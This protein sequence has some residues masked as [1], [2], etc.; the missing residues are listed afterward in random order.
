MKRILLPAV[1]AMMSL[2]AFAQTPQQINYQTIVRDAT[3]APLANTPVKLLFVI[4]DSTAAGPTVYQEVTPQLSTNGFGLVST[5]IGANANLAVVP[6]AYGTKW[7]EV[8]TEING[9]PA[10]TSMGTMQLSAVPYAL[11]AG[12]APA[13]PTGPQGIAG[14]MG[15]TGPTG[16]TGP[17]GP[18][19]VAG[20][21]GST[22]AVGAPG[23]TGPAGIAGATGSA[24]AQGPAG[25]SGPAGAV[26]ATGPTGAGGG[27]TGPTGATGSVGATGAIGV[28]GPTG[29]TGAVGAQGPAGTTGA[30][31]SAGATGLTGPTGLTGAAGPTGLQGATGGTGATG[32]LGSGNAAGNTPYW[33]GSAWV[34]NSSNIYNN[35]GSVG[36]GT[37]NPAGI[38]DV[39]GGTATANGGNAIILNAQ[40]AS[41]GNN[42]GGNI[43]LTPGAGTGTGSVGAV[44]IPTLAGTGYRPVYV[45]SIGDLVTISGAGSNK[46]AFSYT[47]GAQTWNV[48]AGVS[49]V[50]VKLWGAGGG[51]AYST[52]DGPGGGGGFVSGYLPVTPGSTLTL[53][54]GQGGYAG[55]T[56]GGA[57]Y[58]G[59]GTGTT[60]NSG[61][62]GG[63]TAIQLIP[64]TDLV[65]AGAGGGGAKS[66]WRMGGGGG[67]GLIG[68]AAA[69][70]TYQNAGFGGTQTG[71]G[72]PTNGGC[73]GAGTL[74]TGGNGCASSYAGGGGSGYYG[75]AGGGNGSG[76]D[77]PGGGGSS[78]ISGLVQH[79]P[80]RNEQGQTNSQNAFSPPAQLP[81]GTDGP[82]YVAGVGVGGA[83]VT[84][85][86][87]GNN[88]GNGRIVIY[89]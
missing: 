59:G 32:F 42:P 11:F 66:Y 38:L 83:T 46:I 67:G 25:P 18:A 31:G 75:G 62:G 30:T 63:R 85:G 36:I 5:A 54:V 26:G 40:N 81:G 21:T 65:T 2:M 74:Y 58:G 64:G 47:G 70:G 1:A 52:G 78:Y 71:G 60:S 51:S 73:A 88:G 6:W 86:S 7:L 10:F 79:M 55:G 53:I 16:A 56:G 48:P 84:S 4:H 43:I 9:A 17:S 50:Y 89:W 82:D 33:N 76:N 20:A 41:P 39:E 8:R 15:S 57:A 34:L 45:D 14:A 35:G 3:G 27:A 37:A 13:G 23:A 22:G 68:A 24:G 29:P 19:G 80:I 77:G 61:G 72:L 28:T 12:S 49:L 69:N 44:R 87:V